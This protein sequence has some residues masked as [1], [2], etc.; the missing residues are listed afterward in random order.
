M[1]SK[2]TQTEDD[3]LL[4]INST[5][6][7]STNKDVAEAPLSFYKRT[8]PE[9][10]VPF[11]SAQGKILFREALI[12]GYMENYFPLSEQLTTQSEPAYCGPASMIMVLNALY[13]D[14]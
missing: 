9:K 7:N 5:T 2:Q 14:P 8:L 4:D 3:Q 13:I 10:L 11:S 12:S 6:A 1:D